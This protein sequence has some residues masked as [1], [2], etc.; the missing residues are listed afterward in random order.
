MSK[1]RL[2]CILSMILVFHAMSSQQK[3]ATWGRPIQV[4]DVA[5]GVTAPSCDVPASRPDAVTAT[6]KDVAFCREVND[7]DIFACVHYAHAK[8][9]Y[10]R[11]ARVN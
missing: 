1:K 3:A 4:P 11:L 5:A 10:Q 8:S 2:F 9:H 7:A 6:L